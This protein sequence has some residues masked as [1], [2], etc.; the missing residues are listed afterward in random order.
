MKNSRIAR[1]GPSRR[2]R[3]AAGTAWAC[4]L[5]LVAAAGSASAQ[6]GNAATASPPAA[7]RL[8]VEVAPYLWLLNMNGR[9]QVGP[10]SS[11]VSASFFDTLRNTDRLIGFMGHAEIGRANWR[12]IVDAV[13][14]HAV[15][16]NLGVGP[17]TGRFQS[18]A[19]I[20]EIGGALTLARFDMFNALAMRTNPVVLEGLAG[21]R[22]SVISQ[23][24]SL[25]AGPNASLNQTWAEPFIG[26]RVR[27]DLS[28]RWSMR[29]R[30]DIGGFGLGSDFAW[31]TIGLA[32]YRITM[33]GRQ[34]EAVFGYRALGQ[35]Y[36]TGSG[37]RRFEWNMVQHGPV[38]GM[39][40]RF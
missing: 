12:I 21:A 17:A 5:F 33:M 32:S 24:L 29:L 36:R 37:L 20:F 11:D 8:Q 26:A 23:Q 7:D 18:D 38:L 10:S 15:V 6:S 22:I 1:S 39:N 13:Y 4:G 34:A 35:D 9:T 14:T 25:N 40:M 31:Q 3:A 28:E 27:V 16:K 30:G 2:L 19:G